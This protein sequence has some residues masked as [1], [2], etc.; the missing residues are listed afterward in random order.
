MFRAS[1]FKIQ[2]FELCPQKYKFTYIDDLAKEYATPRPYL[3]MGAHV[4]NALKDFYTTL[5]P[6]ERKYDAL[7]RLLRK[8]WTENR[9]GF[10][11]REEEARW[12]VKALQMLRLFVHR[13]DVS[14]TPVLL[15]DYYDVEVDE[16]LK[17]LG[18]IDRADLLPDGTLHVIDYKTGK[19]TPENV[20]PTQLLLYAC[21]V[22]ANE[23]KPV[24]RASYLFLQTW[25]WYTI[26]VT[27]ESLQEALEYVKESV[28]QIR[29]EKEFAP[30]P[31]SYCQHCDFI[32]ICPAQQRVVAI[33]D[34]EASLNE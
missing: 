34:N 14:I 10:E 26:E 5:E 9:K 33:L 18:R 6:E 21:I 22:S 2:M 13:M 7:E 8:R 20:S 24:T 17:I 12:G 15:E 3:T 27:D 19:Y 30:Q 32:S 4:H 25:E 23:K 28:E 29:Q 11:T 31:G 16:S 1:S